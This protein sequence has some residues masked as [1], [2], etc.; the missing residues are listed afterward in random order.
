LGSRR[1]STA[2]LVRCV[3]VL[4]FVA[5]GIGCGSSSDDRI[6]ELESQ[7]AALSSSST[8]STNLSSTTTL[9]PLDLR[10]DWEERFKRLNCDEDAELGFVLEFEISGDIDFVTLRSHVV[11]RVFTFEP[12]CFW[13]RDYYLKTALTALGFSQSVMDRIAM[14]RLIDGPQTAETDEYRA[15]WSTDSKGGYSVIVERLP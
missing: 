5:V 13:S 3:A 11:R 12:T 1:G 8:T 14:T 9:P 2:S 10:S 7:I 15:T 6:V 4:T